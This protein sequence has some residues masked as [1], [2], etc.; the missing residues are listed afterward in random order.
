MVRSL[1]WCELCEEDLTSENSSKAVNRCIV[2]LSSKE[3]EADKAGVWGEG[4]D[5]VL[6]LDEGS[7]K[8]IDPESGD[9]LNSQP[10]HAIRVWGVGRDNGKDFAY[11]SRDKVSRKHMCHVFRC[12]LPARTIANALRDICKK[13]LIERSLAQSSSRLTDKL[14]DR[15]IH[16]KRERQGSRPTSLAVELPSNGKISHK[17]SR[18]A[19]LTETFPTPMEEPRKVIKAWYLGNLLVDTPGGMDV[20]NTAINQMMENTAREEWSQV[21]VAVA[22]STVSI[23]FPDDRETLECRV[24]FLSFLGIG[25]NVQQAAFI[26][27]TAQV[28]P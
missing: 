18:P 6:E 12:Q 26:M 16:D 8:L 3:C 13:I 1:G 24:R 11:V 17:L 7:L 19:P 4:R 10:I 25:Q 27:H 5:L 15:L 20:I 21:S 14:T 28:S 9:C 23:S 2:D 22:P